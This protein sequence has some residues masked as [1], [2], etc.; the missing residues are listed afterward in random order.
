MFTSSG[1]ELLGAE[2][3]PALSKALRTNVFRPS[4]T[5]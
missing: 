1:K 3:L 4:T 2:A 5:P